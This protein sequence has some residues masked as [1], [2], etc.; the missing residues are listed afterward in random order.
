MEWEEDTVRWCRTCPMANWAGGEPPRAQVDSYRGSGKVVVM[1]HKSARHG[2]RAG[3]LT[4]ADEQ[5]LGFDVAVHDVVL[6]AP[7][8]RLDELV[9]VVAHL[10]MQK[11]AATGFESDHIG[12]QAAVPSECHGKRPLAVHASGGHARPPAMP[13]RSARTMPLAAVYYPCPCLPFLSHPPPRAHGRGC[14]HPSPRPR[15]A[16]PTRQPRHD[17]PAR[18]P[19]PLDALPRFPANSVPRTRTRGTAGVD[20]VAG[21][22]ASVRRQA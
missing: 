6:V 21:R 15:G 4:R 8:Y 5:V 12:H 1:L 7:P 13:S 22:H 11:G 3:S 17:A 20:A 2:H 19:V 9:Y 18:P 16:P 10:R 14:G